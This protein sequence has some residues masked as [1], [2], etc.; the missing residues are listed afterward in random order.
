MTQ[1][2]HANNGSGTSAVEDQ[3]ITVKMGCVIKL[4]RKADFR[5]YNL[6]LDLEGAR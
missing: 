5:A 6:P 2:T 3:N 4:A 1:T